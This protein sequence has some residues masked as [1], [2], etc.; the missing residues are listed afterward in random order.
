MIVALVYPAMNFTG[1]AGRPR[2]TANG[3]VAIIGYSPKQ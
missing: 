2:M 3:G 1:I